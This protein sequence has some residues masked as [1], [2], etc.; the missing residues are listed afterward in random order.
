VTTPQLLERLQAVRRNGSGWIARCPAHEDRNPSLSVNEK[1]A[2]LLL[3]CHA[4][5]TVESICAALSLTVSDLFTDPPNS[6]PRI[7]TEYDYSDEAG[8]LLYQVVRFEP[9]DFRQRRPDGDGDW[10]WNLN[11]TRRVLYRLPE[12]LGGAGRPRAK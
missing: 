3:H 2:K 10:I 9:K 12:L 5:C 1:D 7:A 8:N 6:T 11:G 4:G